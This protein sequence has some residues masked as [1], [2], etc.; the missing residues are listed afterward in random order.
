MEKLASESECQWRAEEIHE[1]L[2]CSTIT[3]PATTSIGAREISMIRQAGIARVEIC[4]Y[5]PGSHY[6]HRNQAQVSEIIAACQKQGVTIVAVHGPN[7]PYNSEYEG[8]RKAVVKEAIIAARAAEEMGASIFVAHFGKDEHSVKTVSE[9]LKEISDCR[10]KLAVENLPREDLRE[11][12]SFVDKIG[13]DQ[14]GMAVDIGHTRD[15]DG[16]NPF[17]KK[18]SARQMMAQ[19]GE[20]LFHVHLHDFLERDHMPPFDG[21]IQWGEIFAALKDIGYEGEFLFEAEVG[22]PEEVLE[23]TAA[24]PG[25][26]IQRYGSR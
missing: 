24:F 7:V 25:T 15:P 26:F 12:M 11:F 6:D 19:C 17:T 14:F 1:R 10:L 3:F 2:G 5:H 18:D 20:R 4:G 9:M 8:V 23:K 21:N 22:T 13:S 16:L